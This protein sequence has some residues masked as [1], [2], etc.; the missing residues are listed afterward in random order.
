MKNSYLTDIINP[1]GWKVWGTTSPN[2]DHITFAEFNNSGP[3]NWE[4]NAAA[5]VAWQN[6]TLLTSD[7]YPLATV[8]TAPIG[9][10]SR[11]GT[12][13]SLQCQ[14]LRPLVAL[15]A[16]LMMATPLGTQRHSHS[17]GHNTHRGAW[18]AIAE[19][20]NALVGEEGVLEAFE[21]ASVGR[22]IFAV[23]VGR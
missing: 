8:W 19:Q 17:H 1:S 14:Q 3:G 21:G 6:C 11:T 12:A 22:H 2:T 7:T 15:R 16:Q 4:N 9:S 18:I 5:R 23:E 20:L 13:L 10:T